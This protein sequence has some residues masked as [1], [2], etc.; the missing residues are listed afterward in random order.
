MNLVFIYALKDP[1]SSR[2]RYVGKAA[3]P[4]FRYEEHLQ[5]RYAGDGTHRGNWVSKLL[6]DSLTPTLEILDSVPESEWQFWEKEWIRLYR[7]LEPDLTNATDGGEGTTFWRGKTRSEETR[8]RMRASQLGKKH[9]PETREKLRKINLGN[10]HTAEARCKISEA[11][12][13]RPGTMTGKT[14][15]L[16]ARKKCS[17]AS[18]LWWAS[19]KSKV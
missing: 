11:G 6:R 14:L 18:R 17:E 12:K 19:Q 2:V 10:R 1:I 3:D 5:P 9:S 7:A 15:S 13:G 16:S 4:F 8:Q